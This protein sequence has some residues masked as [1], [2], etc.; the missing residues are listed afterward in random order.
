MDHGPQPQQRQRVERRQ[1][2]EPPADRDQR[3]EREAD[4]H[5]RRGGDR[6]DVRVAEH[7]QRIA[8]A[9]RR[10]H[11]QPQRARRRAHR[12]HLQH[13][14]RDRDRQ[15]AGHGRQHGSSRPQ[16]PGEN[17]EAVG[18][19]FAGRERG[20]RGGSE[21][22]PVERVVEP[23]PAQQR[24]RAKQDQRQSQQ[25][26]QDPLVEHRG[27]FALDRERC[28][29]GRH[30]A[31]QQ[32]DPDAG[33]RPPGHRHRDD[34]DRLVLIDVDVVQVEQRQ[35]RHQQSAGEHGHRQDP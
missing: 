21:D 34:P 31:C 30:G 18:D 15:Q 23:P 7:S 35:H 13:R 2:S 3:L 19:H 12:R 24:E 11:A 27:A 9:N 6:R 14:D 26:Q 25:R 10:A 8:V 29:R 4:C 16:P 33:D 5:H 1:R 28:S 32:T 20:R 22:G 17:R